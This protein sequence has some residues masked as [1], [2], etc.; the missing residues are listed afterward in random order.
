MPRVLITSTSFGKRVQAPV[1]ILQS[2]GF[3]LRLNDL[4]RPLEPAELVERLAGC[5]GCIAGLD[6]FTAEVFRAAPELRIVA[7][8]GVGVDRVD[9]AA[10]A[11]AGV[12]VTNTPEANS[13]SVA[14]LAVT[15]MLAVARRIPYADRLVRSGAW[16]NVYG[17]SLT[18]KTV[19]LVGYGR[20]GSRVAERVRGFR[21]RVLVHDPFLLAETAAG[22]GLELVS[23]ERLLAESDV[24]SLHLP[25]NDQTRGLFGRE[26]FT[27]M[28]AAAILINTARG[29]VVDDGALVEALSEGRIGGA[30]LDAHAQE[31]PNIAPYR[32][33]DNV[34][35]TPHMGAHTEEALYNMATGAVGNLC[36]WFEGQ[37]PPNVVVKGTR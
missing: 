33:L 23:L 6:H 26:A 9:L 7:R 16:Q 31:P 15:L 2:K 20:I 30:G 35:L 12:T 3:E 34:V 24:V 13:D 25:A 19:G 8:Y 1:E 17:V 11:Q 28:K 37:D 10:A 14:D 4:G 5:Q 22:A 18:G 27:R 21:C 36:A 29:E 32:D